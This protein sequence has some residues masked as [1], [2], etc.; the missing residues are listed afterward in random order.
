MDA[1]GTFTQKNASQV[2]GVRLAVL[3][4][5]AHTFIHDKAGAGARYKLLKQGIGQHSLLS[6]S[7][8]L[9]NWQHGHLVDL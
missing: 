4:P 7:D 5:A 2:D 1:P 3:L 6:L 8:G 9:I